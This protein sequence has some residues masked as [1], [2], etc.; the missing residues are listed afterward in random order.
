MR[1]FHSIK[2]NEGIGL[3]EVLVTTVVVAVGLLAV[4][5]LQGVLVGESRGNKTRAEAKAYADSK[6]EEM[7][8]TIEKT[9]ASGFNALASSATPDSIAGV[10]ETYSRSWVVTDLIN[11][12]RKQVSVSVCWSD[13]CPN[14]NNPENNVVVQSIIT[15]DGVG[16]AA[17]AAQGAGQAGMYIG[18]PSTNAESSDEITQTIKLPTS[19]TPPSPGSVVTVNGKTYIV[20]NNGINGSLVD[21]CTAYTPSLVAF[22]NDLYTRRIDYDGVPGNEAI[23]LFEKVV[24][25][26][27]DY[28]IPR[29][30]YNGGV[31]IPIRGIVHSGATTGNGKNQTLLDVNLFTFN[32]TETGTYCV[33]K[34]QTGAKSAPYVCY[35][36]GN[37][38]YGPD[39][40]VPTGATEP[41]VTECPNPAV[42]AAKVGP[43]GWRGK[44]GLLGVAS[45]GNNVCFAEELAGAP[46]TL[47]TARNYYT[48]NNGLNEGINKPYNCHDFLIIN[49][50]QTETQ[51]YN[52]CVTQ[53]NAIGGFK[54]ASKTIERDI[55][56]NNVFD[57]V[58]DTNFCVG[59]AGTTYTIAGTV[60][61][62]ASAPVITINDGVA[63]NNC[64][65]TT[66]TYSCAITTSANSV[67]ISGVYNSQPVSCVLSPVSATGC[68][69]AFT[70]T[71]TYTI[72]GH[73]S[74]T[75]AAAANA[76]TLKVIDGSST[77]NC[78][79]NQ[80]YSSNYNTYTCSISTLSTTGLLITATAS[81]GYS[82]TPA[83][84][85]VPT[86]SGTTSTVVVPSTANDFVASVVPTYTISGTISLGNNV[87]NLTSLTTAVMTNT[88]SCTL[89]PPNGG[90]KK[91]TTGSYSCTVYAGSNSLT[92]AISPMCSNTKNAAMKYTISTTGLSS[93][94]TGQLV[95]D[96]GNVTSNQTYNI[97]IA[98]STTSC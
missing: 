3:I 85:N 76:V 27:A 59:S 48:R 50:Q 41:P 12:V 47:D 96:L 62:A 72:T 58:I 74:A 4:A 42:A 66:T 2:S 11:P 32:A 33:F 25:N 35:V 16:N 26:G 5:S 22:E 6:I 86:L 36:G 10:S 18:G 82:V 84:Y 44:V 31:I 53:A 51:V 94:G 55:S 65:A 54:L 88:G 80:N 21:L 78:T 19:N 92:A 39:G 77:V 29:I 1:Y 40:V 49:G 68:A 91:N 70:V 69:L 71:P 90:W 45:N 97:T 13:G 61:G 83:T 93:T 79:N 64:T 37:C 15:F 17:L 73:I 30:R 57:T 87:S 20:E 43:G 46:A 63:T 60:T 28:C 8:E 23:E 98:E 7:R 95:I 34:P 56:G 24:V 14:T 89:T 52:E 81:T 75:T 67:T 38:T 9:G